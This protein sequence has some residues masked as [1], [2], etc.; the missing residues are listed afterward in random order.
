[1]PYSCIIF[2]SSIIFLFI[3]HSKLKTE[4]CKVVWRLVTG[5]KLFR[6][7]SPLPSAHPLFYAPPNL[8]RCHQIY[9]CM[10]RVTSHGVQFPTFLVGRAQASVYG[11]TEA[12]KQ[13]SPICTC[14]RLSIG[15]CS[16]NFF[17]NIFFIDYFKLLFCLA[18]L[19]SFP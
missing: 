10:P 13:S 4:A 17:L 9:T 11:T 14:S 1:M 3:F 5:V 8:R 2:S 18:N 7:L 6:S 15:S 16:R 12:S 19:L